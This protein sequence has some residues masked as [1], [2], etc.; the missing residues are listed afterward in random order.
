[1]ASRF[2]P[3]AEAYAAAGPTGAPKTGVHAPRAALTIEAVTTSG[4][5]VPRL[6]A[7]G[8]AADRDPACL[9]PLAIGIDDTD[10]PGDMLDALALAPFATGTQPYASTARLG[11]VRPGASLLPPGA[12]VLRR[13]VEPDRESCLAA[14]DGWMIR[15]VRWPGGGAEVSVT[16]V[17]DDLARAV[18]A[19]ATRDA[20]VEQPA[21]DGAV[22][23]GF[24]RRS[25]R[26][27][28]YR[29]GRRVQAAPWASIRANYP[30][31]ATASLDELMAVTPDTVH[32]R[33]VLLHGAP[34]T[35]KTTVL[36]TLAREWRAWCQADFVLDP[37]ALFGDPGYLMGV[38]IGDDDD[39]PPWRLLLLEDCD[40]LIRGG[41]GQPT[42]Q[43]LSRLLNLTDGMLGQGGQVLVA[44]TTNEDVRQL[45]PAVVRPGRRLAHIEI[46]PLGAAEA[47]AW[48]GRPVA[49]PVT[50]AE[51]YAMRR[52]Q[53]PARPRETGT[54]LYL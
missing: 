10:T 37:E 29:A 20:A 7:V 15:V 33:L 22:S 18:L 14:G 27:G 30:L 23:M 16:A 45:H 9:L 11:E 6:V 39:D 26:Q 53:L 13:A 5:A 49:G 52:G 4:Q 41:A 46:G 8:D 47:S 40:E 31:A 43:P 36:R 42:G 1:M 50:L 51:L 48:L 38:V 35:G 34:G 28:A 25:P 54:G 3:E 24:W 17:A 19:Q 21:D 12:S 44:I 32:G 2:C